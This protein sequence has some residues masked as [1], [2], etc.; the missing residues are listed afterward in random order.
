MLL[1]ISS[2]RD[3]IKMHWF[4]LLALLVVIAIAISE[5]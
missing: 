3:N 5:P 4:G 1:L 2:A